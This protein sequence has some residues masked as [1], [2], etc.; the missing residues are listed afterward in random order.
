MNELDIRHVFIFIIALVPSIFLFRLVFKFSRKNWHKYTG[1]EFLEQ[2]KEENRI[3]TAK[4]YKKRK[5]SVDCEDPSKWP[6]YRAWYKYVVGGKTFKYVRG[7]D[8]M[9]DE[10]VTLYYK[11]GNP[12]KVYTLGDVT[13]GEAKGCGWTLMFYIPF[14]IFFAIFGTLMWAFGMFE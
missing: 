4:L 10:E 12:R 1:E 2:A 5:Y 7:L 9:P 3:V 6:V 14:A 13:H 11:K 8:G